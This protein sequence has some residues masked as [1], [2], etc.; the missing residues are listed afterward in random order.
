[1]HKNGGGGAFR[2]SIKTSRSKTLD[3]SRLASSLSVLWVDLSIL[4][5]CLSEAGGVTYENAL[6]IMV[7]V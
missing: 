4:I 1:M 6:M 2:R 5:S 7:M 3:T